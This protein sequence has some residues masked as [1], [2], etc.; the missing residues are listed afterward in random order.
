MADKTGIREEFYGVTL[1]RDENTGNG[2][3]RLPRRLVRGASVDA[4]ERPNSPIEIGVTFP[5]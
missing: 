5:V 3:G 1:A 2:H 4:I